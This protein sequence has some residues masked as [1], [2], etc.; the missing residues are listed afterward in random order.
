[1]DPFN[2]QFILKEKRWLWIDYDKGISI[3]LVGYGHCLAALQGHAMDLSAY[4][5]WNYMGVFLYGFRMPLF[6]IVSGLL[7]A[8]SLNKKGLNGYVGDRT[9]NILYPLLIWGFI[10]ITMQ[11]LAARFTH[12]THHDDVGISTYF[13]LLINPR[14]TGHFWFLNSL[15]C[16]GVIY[17]AFR[18]ILKLK[19]YIQ[20]ILGLIMY[21]ASAYIHIHNINAGFL[22]DVFEYYFFFALGDLIS[23]V[24]LDEKNIKRFSS[25]RI[26]V[27][28]LIVFLTIQYFFTRINLR[29]T[30]EGDNFVEHKLPFFFLL[31]ALVGCT[32]SVSFSFLLQKHRLFTWLRIVG[33]HSLFIYCMQIIV[34][35]FARI[36]FQSFLHID[37]TPAL[38]LLVWT[39]GIV[40]PIFFYNFCLKYNLWW[41]YTFK[42]PE[43]QVEY[44][45]ATNIFSL[46]S[47]GGIIDA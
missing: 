7:V 17:A 25:W 26:F 36:F 28:L 45:R 43:R 34:M 11:I 30:P 18:S 20:V 42:K 9:N 4:P 44:L 31:E 27:P 14:T 16:I 12:F 21:S 40:L 22:T 1:M 47:Q 46:R 38:I 13:A 5:V 3:I 23:N 2:S 24:M 37:Y 32:T 6:F 15:F 8:R 29:P 33:F 10:E 41:L 19:S 35:N 39:S